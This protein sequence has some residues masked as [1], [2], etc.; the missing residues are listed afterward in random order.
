MEKRELIEIEVEAA[1]SRLATAGVGMQ[2]P[3]VDREVGP[4]TTGAPQHSY[5]FEG[6]MDC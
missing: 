4:W 2:A 6:V 3:L 1:N 5:E